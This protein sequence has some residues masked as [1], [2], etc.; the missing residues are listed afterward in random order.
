MGFDLI[1]CYSTRNFG[2]TIVFDMKICTIK[3][4]IYKCVILQI[5]L[6]CNP[7]QTFSEQLGTK[8]FVQPNSV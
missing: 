3:L 5:E 6:I 2:E 7:G 8:K 4:N 1:L